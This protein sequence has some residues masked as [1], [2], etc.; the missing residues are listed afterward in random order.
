M[1]ITISQNPKIICLLSNIQFSDA[2]NR[3]AF[4][5]SHKIIYILWENGR[6]G[7]RLLFAEA[8]CWVRWTSSVCRFSMIWCDRST[9]KHR[10]KRRR[11]KRS[12][13]AHCSKTH[14]HSSSRP[15]EW[16]LKPNLFQTCAELPLL[17]ELW[18]VTERLEVYCSNYLSK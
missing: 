13:V 1:P 5:I 14:S 11:Q 10:W 8:K 2:R 15:G 9:E 4:H 17:T 18:I 6:N 16:V 7:I 12:R 3:E